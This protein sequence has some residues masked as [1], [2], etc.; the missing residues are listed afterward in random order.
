M[1]CMTECKKGAAAGA[2]K[3][4]ELLG[5]SEGLQVISSSCSACTSAD[6]KELL[7]VELILFREVNSKQK[8]PSQPTLHPQQGKCAVIL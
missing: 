1:L 4:R 2:G 6:C 8:A 3:E 5:R 7:P